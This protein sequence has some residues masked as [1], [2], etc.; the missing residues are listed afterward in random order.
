MGL[1][2]TGIYF[3]LVFTVLIFGTVFPQAEISQ[4]NKIEQ[5]ATLASRAGCAK[6]NI[7]QDS[8]AH[9]GNILLDPLRA[10]EMTRDFFR[11]N[12]VGEPILDSDV[13]VWIINNAPGT[14][15]FYDKTEYMES[16]GVAIGIHLEEGFLLKI[17]E[18]DD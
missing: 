14:F 5:A 8:T 10:E 2:Q 3:V 1:I 16:N 13:E 4:F 7:D 6:E 15:T 17:A 12:L 18:I 9:S 11:D